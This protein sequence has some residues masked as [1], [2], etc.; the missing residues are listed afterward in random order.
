MGWKAGGRVYAGLKGIKVRKWDN[1]NSIINN[2]CLKEERRQKSKKTK[3]N[4]CA[5]PPVRPQI[6]IVIVIT[7]NVDC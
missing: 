3:Q 2:I 5:Q 7:L 1:C 6:L 4:P